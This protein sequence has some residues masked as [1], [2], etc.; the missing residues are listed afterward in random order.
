MPRTGADGD[1]S[2]LHVDQAGLILLKWSL[3]I[4]LVSLITRGHHPN[5]E[6]YFLECPSVKQ[7]LYFQSKIHSLQ[8]SFQWREKALL[9]TDK[10]RELPLLLTEHCRAFDGYGNA[11]MTGMRT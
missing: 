9:L 10:A 5:R 1:R 2:T 4:V 7:A 3:F 6:R 11:N 8:C